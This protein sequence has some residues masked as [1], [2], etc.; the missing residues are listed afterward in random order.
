MKIAIKFVRKHYPYATYKDGHIYLTKGLPIVGHPHPLNG[1]IAW[2]EV[3]N[4]I[5]RRMNNPRRFAPGDDNVYTLK[6]DEQSQGFV[7][8]G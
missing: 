2:C 5:A 6:I 4:T 7:L 1:K 8:T 3:A